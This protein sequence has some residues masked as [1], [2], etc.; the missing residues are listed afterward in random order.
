[1]PGFCSQ[2]AYIFR[3]PS[4]PPSPTPLDPPGASIM[5]PCVRAADMDALS[6]VLRVSRL[7]QVSPLK[8]TSRIRRSTRMR[9]G[10]RR[11]RS[12]RATLIMWMTRV[13]LSA[14]TTRVQ[15]SSRHPQTP[16]REGL[17]RAGGSPA[18]M[19]CGIGRFSSAAVL[20][21]ITSQSSTG[22]R[23]PL[24]FDRRTAAFRVRPHRYHCLAHTAS[25][26]LTRTQLHR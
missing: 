24:T 13:S 14:R 7:S 21:A 15:R 17:P 18:P 6:R 20:L 19:V 22:R 12:Q 23:P 11:S 25:A 26:T 2:T 5:P 3:G 9:L 4:V 16:R 8:R 10:S 1:M